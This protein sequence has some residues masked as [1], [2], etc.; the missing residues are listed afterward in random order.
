MFSDAVQRRQASGIVANLVADD[1]IRSPMTPK[2]GDSRYRRAKVIASLGPSCST[3]GAIAQMI[4]H[5]ADSFRIV[6]A[7]ASNEE[8]IRL[9]NLVRKC[10]ADQRKHIS[11]IASLQG[12]K[13]RVTRFRNS[14]NSI[15]VQEGSELSIMFNK[16][17]EC[18]APNTVYVNESEIFTV[19]EVGDE[20]VFKNGPLI[21]KVTSV[22]TD[23]TNIKAVVTTRGSTKLCGGSSLRIPSKLSSI[24]PLT[25][26]EY[27]HLHLLAEKMPVDW[28]CY[29]HINTES[30]IKHI[31]NYTDFLS[32]KYPDFRPMLMTKVE[33]PL[34]VL[35]LKQIVTHVDGIMIARGALGDEMDFSYLPS[36]QKSIIQIARDSGKMCYIATNVCE[37]MSENVIPT[38]AEVSDVTNCLGDGCDGFVLCAETSTGHHSVATVKYLV[39]IIVAV[40]N[41]PLDVSY[42]SKVLFS[43]TTRKQPLKTDSQHRLPDSI[44]VSAISL[45]S[46]LDAKCICIFSIHG[47]GLIRLMRQRPTVPVVVMTAAESTARWMN[48]LWGVTVNVCPRFTDISDATKVCDE[49]VIKNGIA[50]TGDDIVVIF[51]SF[52][53]SSTSSSVN[54]IGTVRRGSNHV[55]AHVV[56]G[57]D[58]QKRAV[59][60]PA[61]TIAP[62]LPAGPMESATSPKSDKQDR[63]SRSREAPHA[64]TRSSPTS[65][66]S[67]SP[68]TRQ[69]GGVEQLKAGGPPAH[70]PSGTSPGTVLRTNRISVP[71]GSS[72]P[73]VTN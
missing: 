10:A 72:S 22:S 56:K 18:D 33:T 55:M 31:E 61:P 34:A 43:G 26:L 62:P 58:G 37:S 63:S 12:P 11:I 21:A 1:L 20:I 68:N 67:G 50:T 46:I 52:L 3:E 69:I 60:T 66:M 36:I 42:R 51:G 2:P 14:T 48:L 35:N 24:A 70:L 73:A 53:M 65:Q 15:T 29:S 17:T 47:G 6:M 57:M 32:K 4:R 71:P 39:E 64:P 13:F 54:T 19:I 8:N 45:A 49:Y 9:Y 41:D 28:I 5:G 25:S 44:S 27:E 38:R 7:K 30:D 40:E 59:P 23:K 16:A